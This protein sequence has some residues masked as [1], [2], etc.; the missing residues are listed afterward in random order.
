MNGIEQ[1]IAIMWGSLMFFL[2]WAFYI[3]RTYDKD[4]EVD[5]GPDVLA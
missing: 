3:A 4:K 1:L 5:D 2:G